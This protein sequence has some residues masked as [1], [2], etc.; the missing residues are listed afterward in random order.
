M[1]RKII[2]IDDSVSVRKM[3]EFALKSKGYAVTAAADGQE[4]LEALER[5][6][7]FDLMILDIN[8]PRLDG[9]TLLK[10]IRQKPAWTG[11]P[12]L[13]LTTEGQ[14]DDRNTALALGA[15]DY[16]VKPFKPSELLER[17]N[18]LFAQNK[19]AG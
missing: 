15:T 2:T 4:G 18:T 9:L 12:V 16:M 14:D 11:L 10:T 5:G 6:E 1:T 8:M 17:V 7:Q 19:S 13:M 3:I